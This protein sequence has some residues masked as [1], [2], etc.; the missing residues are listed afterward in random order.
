MD[1]SPEQLKN[2]TYDEIQVGDTATFS[3]TLTEDEL[4]LFAAVSGDVNP[5][6]LDAEFAAGTL[7]KERI[8]HGMWSGSLVSAALATVLPGPGTI[9][10]EQDLAFKRP[11]KLNDTLTVT[12]T[13]LAKEARN[14]VVI[15]CDVR[16]Q[17]GQTVVTGEAKVMA[18]TESLTLAKP[19]LPKITIER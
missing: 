1:Q 6:H 13:V 19:R 11:V 18:P 8:A 17:G 4:V 15:R 16:N 14:R 3:R 5:V 9:Y 10:L 12:L 7:F 2:V